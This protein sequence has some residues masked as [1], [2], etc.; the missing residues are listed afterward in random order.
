MRKPML[1][2]VPAAGCVRVI[3]RHLGA[4]SACRRRV[5]AARSVLWPR[6]RRQWLHAGLGSAALAVFLSVLTVGLVPR[7]SATGEFPAE[8]AG[9]VNGDT[10]VIRAVVAPLAEPASPPPNHHLGRRRR[11]WRWP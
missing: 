4:V 7:G 8:M 11:R 9:Q 2:S 3:Y 1:S 6:D 5:A 10:T